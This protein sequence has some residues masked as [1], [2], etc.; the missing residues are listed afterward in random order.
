MLTSSA[1]RINEKFGSRAL[2]NHDKRNRYLWIYN[3]R[4]LSAADFD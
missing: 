1:V 4:L 3:V 2:I